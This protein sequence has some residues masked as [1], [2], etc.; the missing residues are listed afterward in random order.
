M[1]RDPVK[2][3]DEKYSLDPSLAWVLITKP[4]REL[5][6]I[7]QS[8]EQ[9]GF[10]PMPSPKRNRPSSSHGSNHQVFRTPV[11]LNSGLIC[12]IPS[13]SLAKHAFSDF[14]KF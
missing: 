13:I 1:E 5:S 10:G 8:G 3:F 9:I 11:R 4:M 7:L 12:S 2:T 6:F 14:L